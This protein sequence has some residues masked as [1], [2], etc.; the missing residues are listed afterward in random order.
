MA[1]GT[2]WEWRHTFNFLLKNYETFIE[3]YHNY[4]PCTIVNY[5]LK[6][7]IS[8]LYYEYFSTV[9]HVF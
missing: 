5:T 2:F 1:I 8:I 4:K 9:E 7:S 6:I 3:I